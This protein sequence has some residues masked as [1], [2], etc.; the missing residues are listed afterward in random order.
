MQIKVSIENDLLKLIP[1]L[2]AI[3][4]RQAKFTI[5]N[6][7]TQT[8]KQVQA[9]IK[10]DMSRAFKTPTPYTL[11]ALYLKPA[12][13]SSL[14]A[15]VRVKDKPSSGNAPIKP[16][17][18]EIYSGSRQAK[19]FEVALRGLGILPGNMFVVPGAGV[20]LDQYGNVNSRLIR[21][22]I[23]ALRSAPSTQAAGRRNRS[24]QGSASYFA[25]KPGE[26]G[27]LKPG[28][29]ARFGFASGSSIKPYFLFV[30]QPN[31][32]E[33]LPFFE[34]GQKIISENLLENLKKSYEYAMQTAK[35]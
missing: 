10:S 13:K 34:L 16:L 35:K 33:R 19:G 29:Y 27:N 7:L 22:I 21:A 9:A 1:Q 15:E 8:A 31:Y 30:K 25:V 24:P 2:N 11:N 14:Q 18:A 4:P 23:E 20:P 3:D 28:I 5:A 12:T 26:K 6:A 32:K 17:N